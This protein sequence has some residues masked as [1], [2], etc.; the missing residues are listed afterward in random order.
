MI[1]P[2]VGGRAVLLALLALLPRGD[3]D[4][5]RRLRQDAYVWQ[6][7]W[8]PELAVALRQTAPLVDGLR[9]LVAETTADG[10]L[11]RAAPDW[12]V[13]QALHRPLVAVIRIDGRTALPPT[14]RL[15]PVLAALPYPIAGVEIDHDCPTARLDDYGR[16]LRA[17]RPMLAPGLPLSITALPNWL[18]APAFRR[19]S[20]AADR[21]VLQVHAADDPRRGLFDPARAVRWAWL[22]QR[23]SARPFLLSL[24]AYGVRVVLDRAGRVVSTE[25]EQPALAGSGGTELAAAPVLVADAVRALEHDPPPGLLGLAWF[26]L[27]LPGDRRAWSWSSWEAVLA[28]RRL[29]VTLVLRATGAPGTLHGLRLENRGAIDAALPRTIRTGIACTHADG[30]GPYRLRPDAPTLTLD[31]DTGM[32]LRAGTG[33]VIGWSRCDMPD[34]ILPS[35]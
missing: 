10:R 26:R 7:S 29:A 24:P 17:L 35:G 1:V 11:D 25:A 8:S 31:A 18:G 16:F 9:V 20:R 34:L 33:L 5:A 32:L 15:L 3:A 19:L 23:R 27:P 14:A 28:R 4:P 30:A 2:G 12:T 13:L 21:L 22:M 6:R